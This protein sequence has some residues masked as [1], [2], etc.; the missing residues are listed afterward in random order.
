MYI[1]VTQRLIAGHGL[2]ILEAYRSQKCCITIGRTPLFF[3]KM[4]FISVECVLI[5]AN[6]SCAVASVSDKGSHM[7][8]HLAEGPYSARWVG[9]G[10]GEALCIL[11]AGEVPMRARMGPFTLVPPSTFPWEVAGRVI[12]SS[13]RPL[14]DNT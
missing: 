6:M 4:H 5:W 14:P 10:G 7:K 11:I 3:N 9:G 12:G 2:L 8:S 1:H 13:Q